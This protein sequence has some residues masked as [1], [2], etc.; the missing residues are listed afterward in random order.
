VVLQQIDG[1]LDAM[2]ES[3]RKTLLDNLSDPTARKSISLLPPDQKGAVDG[4]LASE[5]FPDKIDAA[6]VQGI[7]AALS[8]LTAIPVR[9]SELL[10]DLAGG[11]APCTVDEF[12][13]RIETYLQRI[14]R[15]KEI[16]KVR[17]VI[18]TGEA[19][20]V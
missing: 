17:L 19:T 20:G 10:S 15:G 5:R 18:E 12:R 8:G 9:I 16:A 6:L 2:L 11:S 14:T 1:Q 13:N 3:W 4:F 7:Q